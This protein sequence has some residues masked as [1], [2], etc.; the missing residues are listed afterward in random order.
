MPD[1]QSPLY[2]VN[3]RL[4]RGRIV[5]PDTVVTSN[6][7]NRLVIDATDVALVAEVGSPAS[8]LFDRVLKP[9]MYAEAGVRW[10]LLVEQDPK[11]ELILHRLAV[12]AYI[13]HG[14]VGLGEWLELPALDCAIEVD[15]LLRRRG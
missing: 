9:A 12:G 7:G 6:L 15:A 5:I 10:Y 11:R 1:G 14:R 13:E 2:G 8:Q 3:L 4:G